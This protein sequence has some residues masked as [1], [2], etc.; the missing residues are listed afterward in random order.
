MNPT[1][2]RDSQP[3]TPPVASEPQPTPREPSRDVHDAPQGDKKRLLVIISGAIA[4]IIILAAAGYFIWQGFST[5][6]EQP[7]VTDASLITDDSTTVESDIQSLED[8]LLTLDDT[9]YE[10]SVLSDD[11]I[12]E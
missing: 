1:D 6:T 12:D 7:P 10:D 2:P 9:D 8:E 5:G 4:G 3:Y 11:T